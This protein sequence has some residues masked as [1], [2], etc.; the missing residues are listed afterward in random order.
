MLSLAKKRKLG[1]GSIPANLTTLSVSWLYGQFKAL[2]VHRG[3]IESSWERPGTTEGP[4]HF[5]A[6]IREAVHQTGYRG[7]SVT[8]VLGHPRLVQQ[9]VDLPAVKGK[10]LQKVIQRQAKQQKMF[11][12]E[13]TWASQAC[14]PG[15]AAQRV[16]LHLLPKQLIA[17]L[18][19]GCKRNGLRLAA[20]IPPSAVLHQ[21]FV[22][23]NLEKDEVGLLA[24][25]TGGST[26]LTAGGKDGQVLLARTLPGSWNEDPQRLGVDL[27]RTALFISQQY[28]API[29]RGLWLFG[30]GAEQQVEAVQRHIQLPVELSPV[31]EDSL[32][33]ATESLKLPAD[34]AP[35]LISA[36]L[37]QQPQRRVF[38][39]VVGIV[40]GLVIVASLLASSFFLSQTRQEA[41]NVDAISKDFARLRA[42]QSALEALDH[43]LS[44]KKQ[45]IKLVLGD[46]PPPTP[47]WFLA[48]LGEAVPPE[49]V[50]TNL[51]IV[52]EEDYYKV[53]LAG[54][55][56]RSLPV[57][58]APQATDPLDVL[59]ARL[60]GPPFNLKIAETDEDKTQLA[61]IAAKIGPIDTSVPGWLSRLAAAVSSAKPAAAKP[62]VRDAF[63]IE[64]VMR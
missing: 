23:L 60:S 57:S 40:T 48:Y 16:V 62:V 50:V 35:N 14:P 47:A 33:W 39:T 61:A 30:P 34:S 22:H 18:I 55:T 6:F 5:D 3:V 4:E 58:A 41:A 27:N 9:L 21:Q 7:Q 42:T 28:S 1:G 32:Y 56:Q 10:K 46:R 52:R 31:P 8:L 59:K 26:T 25:E 51:H 64:G 15:K 63:M 38:A 13:A 2:S 54:T 24:A 12:G 17:D 45:V 53:Q 29:N 44:R 11:P 37:R 43:E 19:L 49:L 20:V 36:E